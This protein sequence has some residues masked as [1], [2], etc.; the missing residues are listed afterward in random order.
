ML[1]DLVLAWTLY[2]AAVALG[3][4]LAYRA[5]RWFGLA[6]SAQVIALA[7]AGL[8]LTPARISPEQSYHAP[9]WMAALLEVVSGSPDQALTHGLAILLV[10]LL[11][12]LFSLGWQYWR[13]RQ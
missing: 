12:I 8:L 2:L 11:L 9:A 1:T 3:V 6:E 5:C 10:I 13:R 7:L 4:W